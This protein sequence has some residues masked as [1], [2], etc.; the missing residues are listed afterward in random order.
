[1]SYGDV[2]LEDMAVQRNNSPR[3]VLDSTCSNDG[4]DVDGVRTYRVARNIALILI[5]VPHK[6]SETGWVSTI[7]DEEVRSK[8]PF[9]LLERLASLDV[10]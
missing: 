10:I 6:N 4:T 7:K 1:M 8:K 2:I 9:Y 5:H 3:I